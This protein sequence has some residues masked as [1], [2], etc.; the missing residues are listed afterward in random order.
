MYT[1]K[2]CNVQQVGVSMRQRIEAEVKSFA[3]RTELY[4]KRKG[5]LTANFGRSLPFA[6]RQRLAVGHYNLE[7]RSSGQCAL[8]ARRNL[9]F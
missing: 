2:A 1:I 3:V 8:I 4:G 6:G 5:N 7:I 9:P